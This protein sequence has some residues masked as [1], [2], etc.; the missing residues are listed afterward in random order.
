LDWPLVLLKSADL[1]LAVLP[2]PVVLLKSASTPL[3]AFSLPLVFK[4]SPPPIAVLARLVSITTCG[5]VIFGVVPP[6][7]AKGA[8]AVTAVT[9]PSST[10]HT[11][12]PSALMMRT[13]DSTAQLPVTRA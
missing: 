7:E 12:E 9:P 4:K 13:D 6:L 5:S 10:S 8:E 2:A 1:P 3:A 11:T